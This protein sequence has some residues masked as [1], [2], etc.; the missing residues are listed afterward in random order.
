MW[1][2]KFMAIKPSSTVVACVSSTT[3]GVELAE[4]ILRGAVHIHILVHVVSTVE[5]DK[6][7]S[8]YNHSLHYASR[9]KQ[10]LPIKDSKP[11][12]LVV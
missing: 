9:Q 11:F 10:Y 6:K 5:Q 4:V 7:T 12:P 8:E 3:G 1:C 2:D